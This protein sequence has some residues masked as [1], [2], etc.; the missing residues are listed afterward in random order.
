MTAADAGTEREPEPHRVVVLAVDEVIGYDLHIPPQVFGAAGQGRY[1]VRICGVDDQPV[2]LTA[3]YT[4]VLDHGP[5]ALATADTVIIPGTRVRGPRWHG[6]LPDA[7][8]G[9]LARIPPHARLMSICTGAFVLGAAGLLDGR[10][11]TTHWAHAE[12]FRRLYPQVLLDENVLFVDDGTVLTSAGLAA[13]TD[14]CLHVVR[15]DHGSEVANRAAR[16]C[17]VPPWRDGG[18][19]QFI[20]RPL[21]DPEAGSTAA[22]R[23]WALRHL[24]DVLDV[25]TLA[26]H[27]SMSLRTFSRRFRAETGLTPRAWLIQQRVQHARHLLETTDLT[28]DRVAAEAG[29]GTAASLRQHL[30]SAIGV[31]PLAYRR[32]F[33]IPS[34]RSR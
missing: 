21:P 10:R 18:Q 27:A 8:A 4:A 22:T 23:E 32:T 33:A 24:G 31:S 29:L 12:Q 1:D 28:V 19:S 17:V 16:Y 3:G 15:R 13:G 30:N 25:P 9:A 11:A 14:L 2:R 26:A 6:T 7:L 34:S 5:E 20:D